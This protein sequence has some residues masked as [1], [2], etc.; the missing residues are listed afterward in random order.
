M[1]THDESKI[2]IGKKLKSLREEAGYSQEE[3]SGR[4]G[5]TRQAVSNWEREK[6]L[7]D[8][9]ML[10]DI[11]DI[12]EITMD[13]MC[14]GLG[15]EE[16][17]T[18]T[19]ASKYL[20]ISSLV[21]VGIY[22]IIGF[23]TGYMD[24]LV[25]ISMI[26]IGILLQLFLHIHFSYAVKQNDF[27]GIAGWD[28]T[29]EYHIPEVKRTLIKMDQH[30]VC[31]TFGF[32]MLLFGSAFLRD[33]KVIGLL[34]CLY[35]IDIIAAMFIYSYRS[36]ERIFKSE[37]DLKVANAAWK[38]LIWYIVV[39]LLAAAS[40]ERLYDRECNDNSKHYSSGIVSGDVLK[41]GGKI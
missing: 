41:T 16:D 27:S 38:S 40:G 11:A 19:K 14:G 8:I 24:V 21:L 25:A 37:K 30:I 26:I 29:K 4:I 18:T 33:K 17:F 6:T 12:Y 34:L 28:E 5:V 3:L 10:Q 1:G 9:Y 35:C 20:S 2:S 23:S 32:L 39:V 36:K 31:V 7:P 15:R 13:E 22:F